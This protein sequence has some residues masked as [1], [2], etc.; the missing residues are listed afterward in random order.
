M[1]KSNTPTRASGL[2]QRFQVFKD[3]KR[4]S[5]SSKTSQTFRATGL[6]GPHPFKFPGG[7]GTVNSIMAIWL[8]R[9]KIFKGTQRFQVFH[10]MRDIFKGIKNPKLHSPRSKFFK[11]LRCSRL[12]KFSRVS[13]AKGS[14]LR[15]STLVYAP[16]YRLLLVAVSGTR[17][18]M[19]TTVGYV[20]GVQLECGPK[21]M[22]GRCPHSLHNPSQRL[23]LNIDC[24]LH[25]SCSA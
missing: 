10:G 2:F 13:R 11:I 9:V 18:H 14:H 3:S 8:L 7:S 16:M 17:H 21:W 15:V 23:S 20:L 25:D 5:M 6:S 4:A 22:V 24:R 12:S 19:A 1:N